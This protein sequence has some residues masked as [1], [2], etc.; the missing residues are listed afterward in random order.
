M[1]N[2]IYYKGTISNQTYIDDIYSIL[3]VNG[4]LQSE[5]SAIDTSFYGE[6][7]L[8]LSDV[9]RIYNVTNTNITI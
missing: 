7:F 3:V 1:Q 6:L 4:K 8:I 5:V 9:I 2:C